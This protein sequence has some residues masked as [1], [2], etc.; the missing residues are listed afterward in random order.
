MYENRHGRFTAVDP[1]LASGKSVDPQTFN[2]YVY[3]MNNPMVMTD[4]T[5]LQVASNV[6]SWFKSGTPDKGQRYK[7]PRFLRPDAQVPK[8]YGPMTPQ[9]HV[10]YNSQRADAG[11]LAAWTV[12]NPNRMDQENYETQEQATARLYELAP[13]WDPNQSSQVN[14]VGYLNAFVGFAFPQTFG[15]GPAA[16][17]IYDLENRQFMP[18]VGII[19]SKPGPTFNATY[20]PYSAS[21]GLNGT[22]GVGFGRFGASGG[23]N[24]NGQAGSEFGASAPGPIAGVFYVY[25]P[26]RTA[27]FENSNSSEQ[28]IENNRM[29]L[30]FTRPANTCVYFTCNSSTNTNSNTNPQ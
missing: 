24:Q 12:L 14:Q 17:A 18:Q 19:W 27:Y 28:S 1:L 26:T 4:P 30:G 22:V 16:G 2:R 8:G 23:V 21:S 7:H 15:F 25:Q 6:G 3:V 5:G 11:E 20:S 9:D 10:Y 13:D 29:R